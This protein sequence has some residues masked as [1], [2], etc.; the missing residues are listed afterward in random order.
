MIA[1]I[2]LPSANMQPADLLAYRRNSIPIQYGSE[3]YT[4]NEMHGWDMFI[5]IMLYY[6][7]T[8]LFRKCTEP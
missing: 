8:V 7:L 5:G 2:I 3:K 6:L 1:G 4:Y